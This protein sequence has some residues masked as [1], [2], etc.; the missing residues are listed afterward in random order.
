MPVPA[1]KEELL[2]AIETNYSKTKERAGDK[3]Q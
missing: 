2:K 1:N 3:K